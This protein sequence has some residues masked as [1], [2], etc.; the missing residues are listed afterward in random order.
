MWVHM[1]ALACGCL[2]L[3]GGLMNPLGVLQSQ[4]LPDSVVR[5]APVQLQS[6]PAESSLAAGLP[7]TYSVLTPVELGAQR[8]RL[9]GELQQFTQSVAVLSQEA[10]TLTAELHAIEAAGPAG[11]TGAASGAALVAAGS[12]EQGR[13]ATFLDERW[14]GDGTAGAT[15]AESR[16]AQGPVVWEDHQ[17]R[18]SAGGPAMVP[19][20]DLW[21]QQQPGSLVAVQE[22]RVAIEDPPNATEPDDGCGAAHTP[23]SVINYTLTFG[24][25]LSLQTGQA[26][27]LTVAVLMVIVGVGI[28]VHSLSPCQVPVF[29]CI[30]SGTYNSVRTY[31]T[32]L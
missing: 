23:C 3:A 19:A 17:P 21:R 25:K 8:E 22:A 2:P 9:A 27:W 12:A 11:V 5:S 15:V 7:G 30:H 20:D 10:A 6:F 28:W 13:E 18:P 4:Q 1:L 14:T 26:I 32:A 31:T 16:A 29:P 24:Y